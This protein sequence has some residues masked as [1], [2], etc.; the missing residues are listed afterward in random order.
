MF[1]IK[2]SFVKGECIRVRDNKTVDNPLKPKDIDNWYCH[3]MKVALRSKA[4]TNLNITWMEYEI[5][6]S[7]CP[8]GAHVQ[9]WRQVTKSP[10]TNNTNRSNLTSLNTILNLKKI[11]RKMPNKKW[12]FFNANWN[13]FFFKCHWILF[14]RAQWTLYHITGANGMASQPIGDNQLPVPILAKVSNTILWHKVSIISGRYEMETV[15]VLLALCA[16]NSP[17]TSVT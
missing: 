6:E 17:G 5:K 1:S 10:N 14:P 12:V 8:R 11:Y 15:S 3:I 16:G 2:D 13:I 4:S 7:P 9:P